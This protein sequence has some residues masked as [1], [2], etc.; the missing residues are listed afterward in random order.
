MNEHRENDATNNIEHRFLPKTY[1][2]ESSLECNEESDSDVIFQLY[3][4]EG[5]TQQ[6]IAEILGVS[7]GTIS[8]RFQFNGWKARHPSKKR[9][10]EKDKEI[11]RLYQEEKLNQYEIAKKLGISQSTV[12]R[13]FRLRGVNTRR[14]KN[15][16]QIDIKEI[17]Y[18]YYQMKLSHEELAERFR[19][20]T[21][22]IQRLFKDYNLEVIGQRKYDTQEQRERARKE[23]SQKHYRKIKEIR[24]Q[25]FGTKCKI[26]GIEKERGKPFPVH[27]KD[28]TTH[29]EAALRRLE[30]LKNINPEEWVLLC[31]R[32]HR[33]VTWLLDTFGIEWDFI[34]RRINNRTKQNSPEFSLPND[35]DPPSAK[36][37]KIKDNFEG[38]T[39]DLIRLLFGEYCVFCNLHYKENKKNL[40]THRKDGRPHHKD[41]LRY[42]KYFKCL[43]PD[44][45]VTLCQKEHNYVHWAMDKLGMKWEDFEKRKSYS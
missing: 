41:L 6:E 32:C 20:S 33:G 35:N 19:L 36:Y 2:E 9:G 24:E 23:N 34:S 40:P 18:L 12:S 43:N 14:L 16:K 27:R 8:N 31:V 42:E 1:S 39:K 44:E 10:S 26:C 3:F 21:K 7:K 4:D 38:D 22:T 28:G 17:K 11:F 37:L 25:L 29:A 5:K 15:R 45:W 30:Y 13:A